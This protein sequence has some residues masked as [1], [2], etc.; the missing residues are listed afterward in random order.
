MNFEAIKN[1]L[2]SALLE[3]G[4]EEYEIYYNSS[5]ESSVGTLNREV[6][7]SSSGVRGGICLRVASE[8]R[9]GYAATELMTEDEMRQLAARAI[10]NARF[11]EKED[12]VGIF[13]GSA[14]YDESRLPPFVP[15]SSEELKNAA[16]KISEKLFSIDERVRDGTETQAVSMGFNIRIVNSHGLDLSTSSGVNAAVAEAIVEAEGESQSAYAVERIDP[17]N[18][19]TSVSLTAK[20]AVDD[21]V[22][23]LGAGFVE[24]GK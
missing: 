15:M 14:Q 20:R 5:E 1:A 7:S 24:S 12:K 8:G 21:A 19:D 16:V 4:A 9:M 6:N 17:Q 18:T 10:D 23:K 11:V 2:T 13:S 22:S 3:L